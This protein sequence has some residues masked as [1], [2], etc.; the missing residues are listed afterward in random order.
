VK[1]AA[2]VAIIAAGAIAGGFVVGLV[3]GRGTRDALPGATS[4]DFTSGVLTVRVNTREAL[5]SGL[6][7]LLGA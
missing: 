1:R 6:R 2:F 5:A 3:V 4:T 7:Q